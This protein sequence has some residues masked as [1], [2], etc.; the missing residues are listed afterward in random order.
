V[1][2]TYD[3]ETRGGTSRDGR[4]VRGTIHWVSA[5]HAVEA[6]VRLYDHLF[7]SEDPAEAADK[8]EFSKLLNPDSL[9][10][11]RSCRVEPGLADA[12]PGT[13]YQFLR[14]GY[15]CVDPVDPSP[16]RLMFNR[17]VSLRDTWAK[18]EKAQKKPVR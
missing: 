6:E 5:P 3:P 17:T 16:E 1:H 2:C 10:K 7:L 4:K 9:A 8:A 11:L 15:F 18:I 12:R 13:P 14:H